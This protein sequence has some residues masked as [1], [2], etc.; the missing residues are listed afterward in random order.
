TD[1]TRPLACGPCFAA[2]M[3]GSFRGR[4]TMCCKQCLPAWSGLASVSPYRYWRAHSCVVPWPPLFDARR[5]PCWTRRL[6]C[7]ATP[8]VELLDCP[9]LPHLLL[10]FR[11]SES[12]G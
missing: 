2:A 11:L 7:L 9:K 6:T 8:L 1:T 3:I 4:S 5:C 12:A 10:I